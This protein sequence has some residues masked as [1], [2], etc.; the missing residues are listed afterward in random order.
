M[1]AL[2]PVA[3]LPVD[4]PV[5]VGTLVVLDARAR[6]LDRD[7]ITGG[8]PWR[9]LRLPGGSR[10]VAE[11]WIAGAPVRAGEERFARTL[12]QQ[13]LLH[14]VF[15]PALDIDQIDVVIPVHDDAASLESLLAQLAGL[16]VSV[17]DDGS[18][19]PGPLARCAERFGASLV[20]LEQNRGPAGA[21]N[22]GLAATSRPLVWFL[23]VDVSL[24]NANDVLAR[25]AAQFDDPLLAA[26]A[27]RIRGGG[28]ASIRDRFEQR[29]SPLDMGTRAGLVM[30]GGPVPYVPSACLVARRSAL[31]GGFDETLRAGEDVDLVWRLFDQGWL[32]RYVA[33]VVVCHRARDSWQ[34]WWSQRVGYGAS[35]S[36]LAKRHGSRLAP[37]RCDAWTLAAWTSV[38]LSKPLIG[39]RVVRVARNSLRARLEPSADD[40]E[41][42]ASEVVAKGMIRSGGPLARAIVRTFGPLVLVAALHPKL[43][44]RALALYVVG[45]AWRWRGT[46]VHLGDVPLAAADDFAYAEGVYLG[47][48][49]ARTLRAL[50]PDI[51]KSSVSVREMLGLKSQ[52]D[53]P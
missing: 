37:L 42:V 52:A 17:V 15:A 25:L 50:T 19:Q 43:R 10:L 12:L 30:P 23:D 26:A 4:A 35:S 6:F 5:A 34:R 22:A 44:R 40:A 3:P 16:H 32:V 1:T 27:P 7:L 46:R 21:R 20:R 41:H 53:A 18:A 36:E 49:R 29:F 8:S 24:D 2:I 11:R 51:I 9:L 28:G 38:V 14:P 39:A 45:T 13:G 31:G 48:W 33:D 47:A